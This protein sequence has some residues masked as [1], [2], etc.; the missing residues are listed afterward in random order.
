M[1]VSLSPVGHTSFVR[2]MAAAVGSAVVW[3]DARIEE[4]KVMLDK[5]LCE[6]KAGES[7]ILGWWPEER[8]GIG[9]ALATVCQ[10]F[11]LTSTKTA[12]FTHPSVM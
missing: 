9:S 6:L 3:L 10:R 2:D 4:E 5:F 8:S 1:F 11:R 7:I 12:R